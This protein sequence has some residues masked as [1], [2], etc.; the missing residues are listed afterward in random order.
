MQLNKTN[1]I[2]VG[3]NHTL[4]FLIYVCSSNISEVCQFGLYEQEERTTRKQPTKR[5]HIHK[6]NT[7][8]TTPTNT[9]K[10]TQTPLD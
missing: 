4:L 10:H 2:M 1:P 6:H 5:K 7:H 8:K 3:I 9:N